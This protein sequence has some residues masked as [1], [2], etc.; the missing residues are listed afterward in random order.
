[1]MVWTTKPKNDWARIYWARV[2]RFFRRMLTTNRTNYT[3]NI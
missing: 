2:K 3:N 1:M